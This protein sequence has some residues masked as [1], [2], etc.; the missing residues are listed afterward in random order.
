M[1]QNEPSNLAQSQKK[2][3]QD[4]NFS[5]PSIE[6]V[7][8]KYFQKITE[9]QAG[10]V[11]VVKT[12]KLCQHPLRADAEAKWEQTK[13][14]HG[15]GNYSLVLKYLNEKST[16]V[17]FTYMNVINHIANHYEQQKKRMWL[18]EYGNHLSDV[19]NYQITK[20]KS[21]DMMKQ[22][23]RLKFF[24]A[25]SNP[26]MDNSKQADVMTKLTKSILDIEMISA[27]LRGEID[28]IDVY[29]Q[30][31]QNLIVNLIT[32]EKDKDR[33]R[34]MLEKVDQFKDEIIQ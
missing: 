2:S 30:K 32:D 8:D 22:A 13:G 9:L 14:T 23:L 1:E 28:T 6:K 16:D 26:D 34:E 7:H 33:Q 24:E 4:N 18:R 29:K 10:D 31:F 15:K 5:M 11:I 17:V 19:M 3:E 27:K 21:F 12:C 25:A 20:E